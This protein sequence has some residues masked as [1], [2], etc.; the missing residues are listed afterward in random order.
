MQSV[1]VCGYLLD[2]IGC[3]D[4]SERMNILV[5]NLYSF[6]DTFLLSFGYESLDTPKHKFNWQN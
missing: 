4:R 2:N 5:S 3:A 1:N 6:D